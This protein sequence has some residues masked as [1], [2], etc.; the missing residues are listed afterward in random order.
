MTAAHVCWSYD[1]LRAFDEFARGFL[2]AGLAAGERV[3][4]VAGRRS[5]A[6]G[7]WLRDVAT[8]A[9]RADS[10]RVVSCADAYPGGAAIDPA[11]QV[12]TYVA[13]TAEALAA[14]FT[15]LRVVAD[16]T[17]LVRTGEQRA[18]FA[19]YEYVIGRHLRTAPMRAVCAFDRLE[20][21]DRVVA[22][23]AVLH[24]ASHPFSLRSGSTPDAAIL[25]G[26]LDLGAEELFA[27]ALGHTDLEPVDGVVTVDAAGLTFVDHRSLLA[28]QRYAGSRGITVVVRTRLAIAARVAELLELPRVRVE[29][30]G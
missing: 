2:R 15:G 19:R 23:L 16:V 18:A 25:D 5:G 14:G 7:E 11:T 28:L 29:V 13:A 21:G 8:T 26:N 17:D 20:L 24:E 3:W 6:T 30:T 27:T 1:E 9:P 4:F 22:E 12:E 10:A